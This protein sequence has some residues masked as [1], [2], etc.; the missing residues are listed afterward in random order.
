MQYRLLPK[1][2]CL[3]SRDLIKF[4][5]IS[6]NIWLTVLDTRHSG[7]GTLIGNRVRPIDW[8]HC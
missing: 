6:D 2:I 8:H 7:N 3:E 5:E 1:G 4:S